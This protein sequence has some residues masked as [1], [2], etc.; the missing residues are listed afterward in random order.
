M[1]LFPFPVRTLVYQTFSCKVACAYFVFRKTSRVCPWLLNH[2]HTNICVKIFCNPH[3]SSFRDVLIGASAAGWL[4]SSV[5]L[6][7]PPEPAEIKTQRQDTADKTKPKPPLV[8]ETLKYTSCETTRRLAGWFC[9]QLCRRCS[10]VQVFASKL[11]GLTFFNVRST[12]EDRSVFSCFFFL[13][14]QHFLQFITSH[15]ILTTNSNN[16]RFVPGASLW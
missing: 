13:L 7:T 10:T 12:S 1:T 8:P 3:S 4:S 11:F 5:A 15:F 2:K 6:E 9:L 14:I 16:H